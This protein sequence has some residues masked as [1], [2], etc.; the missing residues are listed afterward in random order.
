MNQENIKI[1]ELKQLSIDL[2]G[3]NWIIPLSKYLKITRQAVYLWLSGKR[4][5]PHS[6][7]LLLNL[8]SSIQKKKRNT[9]EGAIDVKSLLL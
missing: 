5:V 6:I 2:F 8:Q 1:N 9:H 3:N 4:K 7:L